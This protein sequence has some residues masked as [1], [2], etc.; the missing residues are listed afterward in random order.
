[1]RL[2][3]YLTLLG[4]LMVPAA[5]SHA[6]VSIGIGVGGPVYG[7]YAPVCSYGYY[8]YYP[9]ACAPYGYYGPS[10]FSGGIFI[11][12]GPWFRGGYGYRGYGYRGYGYRSGYYGHPG[13]GY[14][15]GRGAYGYRGGEAFRGGGFRGGEGFR[16]GG[17]AFRGGGGSR[18]GE[19][20]RGGGHGR[21]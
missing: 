20:F 9:Y 13:Y 8:G 11:G 15:Y 17:E 6:Q 19:G 12:A 18:G 14:G 3:R 1:M 10:W 2:F 4:V 16:G 7:A 21:R 5:Y